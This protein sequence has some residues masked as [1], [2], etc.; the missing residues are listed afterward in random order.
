MCLLP[1]TWYFPLSALRLPSQVHNTLIIMTVDIFPLQGEDCCAHYNSLHTIVISPSELSLIPLD[2]GNTAIK[3]VMYK[4]H[5]YF[6]CY[7]ETVTTFL[8]VPR[9]YLISLI[10]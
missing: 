3:F 8:P 1:T 4:Y 2:L 7:I 6:V 5:N 10:I 9:I